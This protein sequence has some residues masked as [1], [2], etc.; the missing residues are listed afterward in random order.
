MADRCVEGDIAVII[1]DMPGCEANIG[2]VV[3]VRGPRKVFVDRGTVWR[4]APVSGDTMTFFDDLTG[5]V[6]IDLAV[7]IEHEDDWLMPI[8]PDSDVDETD[9]PLT[10]PTPRELEFA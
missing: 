5:A 7:N 1:K 9:V 6:L 3:H 4:I 8:R 10:A 2:R